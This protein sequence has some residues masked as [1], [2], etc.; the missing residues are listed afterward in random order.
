MDLITTVLVGLDQDAIERKPKS[1]S[2]QEWFAGPRVYLK[3]HDQRPYTRDEFG[4]EQCLHGE[5]R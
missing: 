4:Q 1:V 2:L 5:P 3:P